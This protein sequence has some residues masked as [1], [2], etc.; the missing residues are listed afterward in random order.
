LLIGQIKTDNKTFL[1]I[2]A[3][4]GFINVTE[5]QMAGKKKLLIA[6]FLKGFSF[7]ENSVFK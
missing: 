5:L 1:K 3:N 4:I 2:A 7:D 6:E